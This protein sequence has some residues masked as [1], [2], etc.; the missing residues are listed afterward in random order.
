MDDIKDLIADIMD[1]ESLAHK[2]AF[3][4]SNVLTDMELSEKMKNLS[5]RHSARF[6]KLY[7]MIEEKK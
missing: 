6:K 5:E 7:G 3:A 1:I 4:Y 2:K